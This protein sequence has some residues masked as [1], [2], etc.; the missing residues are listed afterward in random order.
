[1]LICS[2]M[3]KL[4]TI[5]GDGYHGLSLVKEEIGKGKKKKKKR[6][7]PISPSI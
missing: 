7:R 2:W 5:L 3:L 6:A 1:M 4:V